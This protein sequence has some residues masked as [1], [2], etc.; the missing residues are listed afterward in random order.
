M[1]IFI[2]HDHH[3]LTNA[4]LPRQPWRH[5]DNLRP[6]RTRNWIKCYVDDVTG[7]WWL[8][9][10]NSQHISQFSFL[11]LSSTST[12]AWNVQNEEVLKDTREMWVKQAHLGL[13]DIIWYCGS[14]TRHQH[15]STEKC[16]MILNLLTNYWNKHLF[17]CCGLVGLGGVKLWWTHKFWF[18]EVKE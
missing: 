11:D 8:G 16:R 13:I 7:R 9:K 17:G 1:L 2:L 14:H 15:N 12:R 3:H 18:W 4:R 6:S 10:D 5:L